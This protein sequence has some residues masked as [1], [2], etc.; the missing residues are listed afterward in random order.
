MRVLYPTGIV[1]QYFGR[2]PIFINKGYGTWGL[3]PHGDTTRASYTVPTGRKA[4]LTAAFVHL[5]RVTAPAPAG[6]AAI[7]VYVIY[8][9]GSSYYL[10]QDVFNTGAGQQASLTHGGMIFLVAADSVELHTLDASTGGTM[11]YRGHFNLVEF[12][13]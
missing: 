1:T 7:Y 4:V 3:A 13:P 2:N 5:I 12:D 10:L 8:N 6:E 9:G 11:A